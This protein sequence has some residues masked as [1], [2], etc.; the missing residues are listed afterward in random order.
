MVNFIGGKV[1][2]ILFMKI[3]ISKYSI[4]ETDLVLDECLTL[5]KSM[6]DIVDANLEMSQKNVEY[7]VELARFQE[8]IRGQE[9]KIKAQT[10]QLAYF[11]KDRE[12]ISKVRADNTE[13]SAELII[14]RKVVKSC[15]H[16]RMAM[17]NQHNQIQKLKSDRITLRALMYKRDFNP[18]SNLTADAYSQGYEHG[19]DDGILEGCID[20]G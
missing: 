19:K 18:N 2:K 6:S 7:S 14:A 8:I 13:M 3:H 10:G 1:I 11:H 17:N 5:K 4:K 15:E 12:N 9:I 16:N 20:N